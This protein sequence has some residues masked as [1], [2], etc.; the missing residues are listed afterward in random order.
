MKRYRG[1]CRCVSRELS[2]RER[3]R[4]CIASF[5]RERSGT[6]FL[7][8]FRSSLRACVRRSLP[9]FVT[10]FHGKNRVTTAVI[11]SLDDTLDD[12]DV[13]VIFDELQ[14]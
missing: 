12:E 2:I 9:R 3:E 5:V 6:L 10:C 8:L 14:V 4:G 1:S 7:P 11:L 13:L